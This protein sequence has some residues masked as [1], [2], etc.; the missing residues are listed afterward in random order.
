MK[1]ILSWKAVFAVTVIILFSL[2]F[3]V[4]YIDLMKLP[5]S[6]FSRGI[7]IESYEITGEY[8]DYYS[9]NVF[10]DLRHDSIFLAYADSNS[11]NAMN[12][13][14]TGL[15]NDKIKLDTTASIL[16][17]NGHIPENNNSLKLIYEDRN[18]NFYEQSFS[19]ENGQSLNEPM[20]ITS[21]PRKAFIGT[22]HLIYADEEAVFIYH[23]GKH[24]KVTT[25]RYIET[26]T[27]YHDGNQWF[28]TFTNYDQAAYR[29]KLLILNDKMELLQEF[30]LQKYAGSNS[31]RPSE[32]ALFVHHGRYYSTTVFKD[33]KSGINYVYMFD[34]SIDHS[35]QLETTKITSKNFSLFPTYYLRN[36][37]V[38]IAFSFDTSI[39]RVDIQTSGGQ[40]T[41]LVTS[42]VDEMTFKTLT[43][44]IHPSVKPIFFE[45]NDAPST[46]RYQYLL[47]SE[48]SKGQSTIYLSSN[49]PELIDKSLKINSKEITNLILTTLTTF[50]P[51]S[52]IGL[53]LEVYILVPILIFVLIAS[54]FYINWAERNGNKLLKISI[55]LHVIVKF[56]FVN[57]KIIGQTDKFKNFP[58]FINTTF[59]VYGW[60]L[61][62]TAVALYCFIDYSKRNRGTHY[63]KS[64]IFFNV[65]DLIFFVMLYTPYLFLS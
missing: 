54:M 25:A 23:M 27:S 46:S 21:S 19:V 22:D 40:F 30:D 60:G 53:I 31:M 4:L 29:Q 15:I 45:L 64:Y 59:E 51:L 41:N 44:T 9:K 63:M 56:I 52:Y 11:V 47:F 58:F 61:L 1:Y 14:S 7:E 65:I 49:N 20:K 12:V 5:D 38:M 62:L 37:N 48:I 57:S 16:S 2:L 13:S 17:M 10:V 34:G 8:E 33:Q 50:L 28:I 6:G 43:N 3:F 55:V 42:N 26:L 36:G 35:D 32:I 39:G 18:Q 24:T